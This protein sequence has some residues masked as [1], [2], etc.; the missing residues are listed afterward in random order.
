MIGTNKK[1]AA[2]SVA[3]ALEDAEAGRLGQPGEEDPIEWLAERVPDAV[4]WE[5]WQAIDE[6]ERRAGEAQG[7][8]RVKLVTLAE[9]FEAGRLGSSVR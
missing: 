3:K 9:L 7:R 6:A 5:G 1:D 2:D 4:T 8:P